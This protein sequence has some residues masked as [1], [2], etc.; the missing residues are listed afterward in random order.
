[1]I[2]EDF[3]DGHPVVTNYLIV[4]SKKPSAPSHSDVNKAKSTAQSK[5]C[6]GNHAVEK[7]KDSPPNRKKQN[8]FALQVCFSD[9]NNVADVDPTSTSTEQ[10]IPDPADGKSDN[11]RSPLKGALKKATFKL[12]GEDRRESTE[13]YGDSGESQSVMGDS[14]NNDDVTEGDSP[15]GSPRRNSYGEFIVVWKPTLVLH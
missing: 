10:I 6:E 8:P 9:L 2:R 11:T 1:M 5:A 4:D 14:N 12:D 3:D 7:K 13:S 15:S